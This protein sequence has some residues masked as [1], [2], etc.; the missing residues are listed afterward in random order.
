MIYA[1]IDKLEKS[2]VEITTFMRYEEMFLPLVLASLAFLILE[3]LLRFTVLK[4]FP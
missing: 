1:Q 2:K 3:L 4:K